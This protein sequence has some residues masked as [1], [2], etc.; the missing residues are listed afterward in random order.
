MSYKCLNQTRFFC[1]ERFFERI[2][3]VF[4]SDHLRGAERFFS[5]CWAFFRA[6]LSVFKSLKKRSVPR[7]V[8]AEKTLNNR[9]KNAQSLVMWSL[10][11]TLRNRSKKRSSWFVLHMISNLLFWAF[12]WAIFERFFERSFTRDWAFLSAI[13]ERFFERFYQV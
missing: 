3:S 11:K 1:S 7:K 10:K 4:S 6:I 13:V 8:I 5:D 9:W 12:F 2:L